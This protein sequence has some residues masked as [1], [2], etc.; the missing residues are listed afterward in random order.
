MSMDIWRK[1]YNELQ[2]FSL[3]DNGVVCIVL[4]NEV[5]L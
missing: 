4:G 5:F 1:D 3:S 2:L